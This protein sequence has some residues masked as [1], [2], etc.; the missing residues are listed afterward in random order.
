[1]PNRNQTFDSNGPEERIRGSAYQVYEKYLA[2]ARDAS[3]SGDR[4]KS[5]NYFQHAEHYFRII[6]AMN[7]AYAQAERQPSE[8]QPSER[9]PSERQPADR[10]YDGQRGGGQREYAREN[11][12]GD[13]EGQQEREAEFGEDPRGLDDSSNE[14]LSLDRPSNEPDIAHAAGRESEGEGGEGGESG[15][16]QRPIRPRRRAPRPRRP[17]GGNG[18]SEAAESPTEGGGD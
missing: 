15:D 11:G 17:S 12:R 8:R 6:N 14:P 10:Q 7:E 3:V 5:E 2:L 1:L 16:W 18:S 13:S 4:V 9:Q